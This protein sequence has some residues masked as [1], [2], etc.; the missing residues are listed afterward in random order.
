[1]VAA[2]L[3]A[4]QPVIA[5]APPVAEALVAAP[6]DREDPAEEHRVVA[7]LAAVLA[8]VVA[9]V[10]AKSR[11]F[12]SPPSPNQSKPNESMSKPARKLTKLVAHKAV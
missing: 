8:A 1:M 11:Q 6:V 9:V 2:A 3:E 12:P 10:D 7:V 5:E 4:V